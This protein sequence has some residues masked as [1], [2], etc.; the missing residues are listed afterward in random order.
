MGVPATRV[1]DSHVCPLA[2]GPKL[3]MGGPVL[4]PG[5]ILVHIGQPAARAETLLPVLARPTRSPRAHPPLLWFMN[6]TIVSY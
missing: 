2:E 5:S 3:Y 6:M 1:G 4:P